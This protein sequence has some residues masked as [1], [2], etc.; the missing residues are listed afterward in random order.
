MRRL[1]AIIVLLSFCTILFAQ[2]AADDKK[3]ADGKD[4]TA[5][6]EEKTTAL[7][8][9]YGSLTWGMYLS[10]GKDKI[11]GRLTYTDEK[12][13]I[14]SSDGELEYYYGFFYPDPELTADKITGTT[15]ADTDTGTPAKDTPKDEGRLFYVSLKFPYL[16]KDQ[17]YEKIKARYGDHTSENIK[18]DQGAIAWDSEKTIV[19][20]WIDRYEKKPFCRRI[21][22]ISKDIAKELNQY[23]TKIFHKAEM[24]LI[25]KLNP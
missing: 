14:V 15:A 16:D 5:K 4:K 17:V 10:D 13:I 1:T 2:S 21:I 25:K 3:A 18:N 6:T 7:P 20:M 12:T 9:G 11:A 22:Y 23:N 8:L 19:M 24:E